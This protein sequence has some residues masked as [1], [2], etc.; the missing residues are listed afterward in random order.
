MLH[1]RWHSSFLTDENGNVDTIM[2]V[3]RDI[4]D[5]WKAELQKEEMAN[6]LIK[7]NNDLEQFTYIVSHNLRSP[8]ANMMGLA[9]IIAQF[10][11]SD[12]ER[13]EAVMGISQSAHRLDDTIRDLE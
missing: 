8:I 12:D 4:T 11:L 3:V 10:D 7:R 13:K 1:C 9:D 2:S 5:L 6:D